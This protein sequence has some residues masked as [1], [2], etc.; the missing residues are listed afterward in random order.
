M[1][2]KEG[3]EKEHRH[4]RGGRGRRK[5]GATGHSPSAPFDRWVRAQGLKD[6]PNLQR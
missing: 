6:P 3:K 5:A 2:E 4:Q 1:R